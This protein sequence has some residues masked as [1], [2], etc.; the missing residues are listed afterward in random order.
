[1]IYMCAS[2]SVLVHFAEVDMRCAGN[3]LVVSCD[4]SVGNPTGRPLAVSGICVVMYT[5]MTTAHRA[6]P[7]LTNQLLRRKKHPGG[8]ITCV[9]SVSSTHCYTVY[10][11]GLAA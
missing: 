9:C 1:M 2:R 8:R 10:I 5:A 6:E 7:E 4:R 3:H 11:H